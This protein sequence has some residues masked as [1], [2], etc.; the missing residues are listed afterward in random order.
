MMAYEGTNGGSHGTQHSAIVVIDLV[1]LFVAPRCSLGRAM[2]AD[3]TAPVPDLSGAWARTTFE[4][5]PP[6]SGP[7]P[8][9]D[10]ARRADE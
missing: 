7:G 4:L 6:A 5:E 3:S 1:A 10:L 9:R 2:G 8:L